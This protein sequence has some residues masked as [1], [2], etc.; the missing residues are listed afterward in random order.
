MNDVIRLTFD[1]NEGNIKI[2]I[3]RKVTFL[4]LQD[5]MFHLMCLHFFSFLH[6]S[7]LLVLHKQQHGVSV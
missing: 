1:I 7:Y 6:D 4:F 5:V 3:I 2:T